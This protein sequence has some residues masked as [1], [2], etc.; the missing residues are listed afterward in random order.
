MKH[1]LAYLKK[2]EA[3]ILSMPPCDISCDAQELREIQSE[4]KDIERFCNTIKCSQ[5]KHLIDIK[6]SYRHCVEL[7]INISHLNWDEFYC[8]YFDPKE[9][10]G[11]R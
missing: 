10:D 3:S 5:C 8:R 11:I 4:I 9:D 7:A 6:K 1:A 2:C